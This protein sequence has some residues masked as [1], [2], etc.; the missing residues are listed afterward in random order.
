[1]SHFHH[2]VTWFGIVTGIEKMAE[3]DVVTLTVLN[4]KADVDLKQGGG[5]FTR[6]AMIIEL[7]VAT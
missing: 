3:G 2:G 5:A 7:S 4:N 6:W 1:M